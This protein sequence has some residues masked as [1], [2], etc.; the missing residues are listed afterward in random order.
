MLQDMRS[1]L[2][3]VHPLGKVRNVLHMLK[4]SVERTLISH[5]VNS[6]STVDPS[7]IIIDVV[8][9]QLDL[10]LRI[11]ASFF[12]LKNTDL[13]KTEVYIRSAREGKWLDRYQIVP[14][15]VLVL[16]SFVTV[17]IYKRSNNY[18]LKAHYFI[19]NNSRSDVVYQRGWNVTISN[20]SSRAIGVSWPPLSTTS[21]NSTYIYGYVVFVRMLSNGMGD[22]LVQEEANFTSLSTVVSGLRAYVK[23]QVEVVAFLKDRISGKLSLKT[24]EIAEIQTAEGAP[25]RRPSYNRVFALDYQSVF[26]SWYALPQEDSGGFLRGYRVFYQE[27]RTQQIKNV[28]VGPEQRQVILTNFEPG[29]DYIIAVT[30]FT[31]KGEGPRSSYRIRTLCGELLSGHFGVISSA[32]FPHYIDRDECIWNYTAPDN[33]SV[34]FLTF[35]RLDLPFTWDCSRFHMEIN[36]G[37]D[38]ERICGRRDGLTIVWEGPSL[39]LRYHSRRW[40]SLATGFRAQYHVLNKS[41][42]EAPRIQG[43]NITAESTS[44]TTVLVTWPDNTLALSM[45]D[46]IGF[47]AACTATEIKGTLRLAAANSSSFRTLVQRLLPYTEYKVQMIALSKSQSNESVSMG[48]SGVVVLRTKEDVPSKPPSNI[49]AY[50]TNSTTIRLTWSPINEPDIRG[51]LQGYL[52]QYKEAWTQESYHN[53]SVGPLVSSV[54]LKGLKVF[55]LYRI[56]LAGF[57]RAGVGFQSQPH[58]PK[59]GCLFIVP[60]DVTDFAS[61]NFP[62]NYPSNANCTWVIGQ[63]MELKE[64]KIILFFDHLHT[65]GFGTPCSSDYIQVSDKS[66]SIKWKFCG[67]QP[68][69]AVTFTESSFTVRLYSDNGIEEKGF[70]ARYLLV[71]HEI[72]LDIAIKEENTNSAS[73]VLEWKKTQNVGELKGYI[74]L[75]KLSQSST[76]WNVIRTNGTQVSINNIQPRKEYTVRVLL[77]AKSNVT[78]ISRTFTL[79]TGVVQTTGE[80]TNTPSPTAEVPMQLMYPYGPSAGDSEIPN[81]YEYSWQC[82]KIDIPDD[83]MQ[84]FGKRHYKVYI[85]RNGLLQFDSQWLPWWPYNFGERWWLKKKAMLAPYWSLTD[86]DDSFVIQGFSKV[87]YHVYSD[88]D[89]SST[90]MLKRA[91]SDTNKLL[92]TPLPTAFRASWVL[93]VTWKNLRPYQYPVNMANQGNTFQ[94]VLITDGVYSFTMYNYP[95]NGLQWSAPIQRMYYRY[96]SKA[97]GLPV[98]GWNAGDKGERKYN[99]P[100]SGTVNIE[101]ID[102]IRGNA[103]MVGKWFFRLEDSLGKLSARQECIDWFKAQP[104]PRFYTEYLE[105]CPCILRQARWDE[106]FTVNWR[107]WPRMCGYA[108]FPSSAGWGQE[109]CYSTNWQSWG[110]LLVGSHGGGSA[111]RYHKLTK[112]LRAKYDSSDVRG[113]QKCCVNSDLCDLYYRRRPSDDCGD[114][115]VPEW[116]WLWGDPHFVTLD[117]KNY[118]FNGLGEYIMADARNGLFQLQARTKLAK[119]DGTA[120]VFSAAA[121][122]EGNSSVVQV[123]LNDT[124]ISVLVGGESFNYTSLSNESVTLNGSVAVAKPDNNSFLMVF[125]SGISVTVKA[126]SGALS[127]VLAAPKSFKNQTKGLLGTW[128]DD[129]EDDFLTPNG[130]VLPSSAKSKDI[131]YNFG[132]LWQVDNK[133]TLFTY[134]PGESLKTFENTSFVP[135]FLEDLSFPNDTLRKQAEEACQGDVNCLFDSASTKDVSM[136]ASTKALSSTL[137]EESSSLKNYPPLFVTRLSQ[138]NVTVNQSISVTVVAEDPN[139]DTLVFSVFGVLPRAAILQNTSNSVSVSWNGTNEQ[140]ELEFVVTDDQGAKAFL[141]PI[142]NLCACHNDG[143]CLQSASNKNSTYGSNKM[144]VLECGCLNGYTGTFCESDLDACEANLNP[145][146]P[147]VKC[148][149]LPP[150]ANISGYKCGPCPSGFTGDGSK[151]RDFDECSL[152]SNGGCSQVCINTPG[153]FT[154]DCTKGYLLNIDQKKCDDVDECIPVSDCMHKC[155]NTNG[156]YHCSCDNFFKMDPSNPKNCLPD[157]PCQNDKHSCQHICYLGLNKVQ[158]CACRRGYLLGGDGNTCKDI[159]ECATNKDRCN[160]KCSNTEGS[161][162]CS[163]VDGFRLDADNVTCIDIDE[164]LEWTFKCQDSLQRCENTQGSYKCVCEEGLYWIDNTCKGLDKDEKPPPPAPAPTPRIPSLIEKRQAIIIAFKGM[165]LSQWTLPVEQVFKGAVADSVTNFCGESKHCITTRL[166]KRRAL[167]YVL[168]TSDQVHLL[169]GYPERT[170]DLFQ[171]RVAIYVQFP[172]GVATDSASALD[173]NILLTVIKTSREKL[174]KALN[175]TVVS[176]TIAFLDSST[177]SSFTETPKIDH[178]ISKRYFIIGGATAGAILIIILCVLGCRRNCN[179]KRVTPEKRVANNEDGDFELHRI[180]GHFDDH[181]EEGKFYTNKQAL[182]T[183]KEAI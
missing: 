45:K 112:E 73:A 122:K 15:A 51:E 66:Q 171:I 33:N 69:F 20:V 94:L 23:Y 47:I 60:S 165:N 110:A 19:M 22:I 114:Y 124:G 119:G 37:L 5:Q 95:N 8:L 168:F 173:K 157:S 58:F 92:S 84:F 25:F 182:H 133:S 159:D 179:S 12:F 82:F 150:P 93:V 90:P 41:L 13:V 107:D 10:R 146:Y 83:G 74:V 77:S 26:V 108:Q 35:Q 28:T 64:T 54:L 104:D 30:A 96:Y 78:Y 81:T 152:G 172:P 130:T 3:V 44:S 103:D 59:T 24:S 155:E 169:P 148:I 153:S 141:R 116:S 118:T 9:G 131:H 162:T 6:V 36:K 105:P 138:V 1:E 43:W 34:F 46:I 48:S 137:E 42:T 180:K 80:P 134:K 2:P 158:Q 156:G 52:V 86:T 17:R 181:Q 18:L 63:G 31:A 106:R 38:V 75:Y 39:Q 145:C 97:R 53:M 183:D 85:C 62:S 121:A 87:Y 161:Y 174:E 40:T 21:L 154:C 123:E 117:G 128:N 166:R 49:T 136:G 56:Y 177:E 14:S 149:D 170:T 32:G 113:Y 98:V 143:V 27:Y 57:T 111:H 65:E 91:S 76:Y 100:R 72:D 176:L 139:N 50:A 55:T 7:S 135:M 144:N 129:P 175:M 120:T 142:I 147:G 151:C 125:S 68:P 79:E 132:L 109:C 115:V 102:G 67:K 178:E 127:I 126:V 167:D 70:Y 11:Q 61:P 16:D 99:M 160:H 88:S 164:C 71:K 29:T 140:I 101:T 4:Q 163:C 89:P